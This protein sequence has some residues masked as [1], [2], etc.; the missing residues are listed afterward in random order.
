MILK[1]FNKVPSTHISIFKALNRNRSLQLELEKPAFKNGEKVQWTRVRLRKITLRKAVSLKVT[2]FR[3]RRCINHTMN[4]KLHFM[5]TLKPMNAKIIF[6]KDAR[7]LIRFLAIK[8]DVLSQLFSQLEPVFN[9]FFP[10]KNQQKKFSTFW[11]MFRIMHERFYH[12][13]TFKPN[14]L[15]ISEKLIYLFYY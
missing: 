8:L 7:Y 11:R 13:D 10:F 4:I 12:V 3:V 5:S 6:W 15:L 9:S 2:P 14:L 1:R